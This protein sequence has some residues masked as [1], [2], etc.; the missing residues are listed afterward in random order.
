MAKEK[1]EWIRLDA[2]DLT[3]YR[4]SCVFW[5]QESLTREGVHRRQRKDNEAGASMSPHHAA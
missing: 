2:G 5:L 1:D 4:Q 3:T